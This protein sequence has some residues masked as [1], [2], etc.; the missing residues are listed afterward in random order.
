MKSKE[1]RNQVDMGYFE[2]NLAAH[3]LEILACLGATQNE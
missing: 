2:G 1:Y 3:M